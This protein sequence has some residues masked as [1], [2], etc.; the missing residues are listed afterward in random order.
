MSK[1]THWKVAILGSGPAGLTAAIYNGRAGLD[2]LVISGYEP[3]GQLTQTTDVENFPGFPEGIMG[4]EMMGL[5]RKQAERFGTAFKTGA[6][7][8]VDLA[9]RPHKL[10]IDDTEEITCD[11]LI[12]STGASA[13]WLGLDSEVEYKG[14][15]VSSC[16]TCDGAFFRNQEIYV[17]GGGDTAMEEALF[18]TRFGS[19]VY[20]VHRRDS[21]R[22]SKIMQERALKNE[23]VEF[24]W[25]S[26]IDEILG[27]TEGFA[28]KVTGIRIRNRLTGELSEHTA[29]AVFIAIGH[30]PNTDI[31]K[32][33]LDMD[34]VGY[35]TVA[36]GSTKTNV[37]GVFAAGDVADTVYRQA[38]T[39]AGTGCQAAIDAE[40]YLSSLED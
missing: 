22:A 7:T 30:K 26:E 23:K 20:I 37:A 38:I 31:F 6:V 33:Q 27:V 2:P 10:W 14:F 34:D 24:V 9:S 5:F 11:A 36:P 32:G 29:G 40:H 25:N 16:A 8:R 3:G 17:I 12:I 19:R 1:Q 15:G 21:L 39:A 28:K 13:K 35:L 4:P 18:L